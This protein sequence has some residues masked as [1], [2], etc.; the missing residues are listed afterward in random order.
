VQA[1]WIRE[2]LKLV[3][4]SSRIAAFGWI[5]LYD[6]PPSPDGSRVSQSGLLY[7]NGS[8]KPGYFA[9]SDG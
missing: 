6:D 4:R 5:H 7:D 1:A 3:R 9:F 2:T 8:P